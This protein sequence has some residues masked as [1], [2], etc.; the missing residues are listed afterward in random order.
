MGLQR[1]RRELEDA[2]VG[3]RV[4]RISL[5]ATGEAFDFKQ[6]GDRITLCGLPPKRDDELPRVLKLEL[7]G[8]PRGVRNPM[9]PDCNIRVTG[10]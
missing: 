4:E 10:D 3:N 7:D 6:E 9:F 1:V 2:D 5:L 8:V